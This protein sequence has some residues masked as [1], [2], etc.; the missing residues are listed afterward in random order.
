MNEKLTVLD[1]LTRSAALRLSRRR[2]G[3][4]VLTAGLLAALVQLFGLGVLPAY[5]ITCCGDPYC[6]DCSVTCSGCA[7]GGTYS[8]VVCSPN[9]L[10]CADD[11]CPDCYG[12]LY[13]C[14]A[15]ACNSGCT[16]GYLSVC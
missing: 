16:G 11:T 7:C 9:G 8:G 12:Y 15:Y 14:C 13:K 4:K 5:A 3:G 1:R 6:K 10:Y 2:L